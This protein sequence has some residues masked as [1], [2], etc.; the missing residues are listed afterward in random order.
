MKTRSLSFAVVVVAAVW[1]MPGLAKLTVVT[2]TQD[3]AA[4]TRDIGGDRVD[5]TALCKGYQDPH[6]LDA[7][8]S[9]MLQLNKADLVEAIGLEFEI[10]WLPPLLNGARNPKIAPGNPGY[11]DLASLVK[12]LEVSGSADRALQQALG[13]V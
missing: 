13:L 11:L 4:I 12:P 7:K 10:G 8:P 1:A 6:F 9:Y 3:P 2:T 5:V